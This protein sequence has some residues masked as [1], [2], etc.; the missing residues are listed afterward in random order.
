MVKG[1]D[2]KNKMNTFYNWI[3]GEESLYIETIFPQFYI[4]IDIVYS[5]ICYNLCI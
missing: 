4:F 1:Q 5:D 3:K 2:A